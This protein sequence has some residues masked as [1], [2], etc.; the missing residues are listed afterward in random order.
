MYELHVCI[1]FRLLTTSRLH[2]SD[3]QRVVAAFP[4]T[5]G[6]SITMRMVTIQVEAIQI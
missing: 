4:L 1:E 2:L 6:H 3:L 5:P